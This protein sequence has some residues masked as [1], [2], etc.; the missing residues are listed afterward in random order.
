MVELFWWERLDV[1]LLEVR[2]C[3]WALS[4]QKPMPGPAERYIKLYKKQKQ[5]KK[6]SK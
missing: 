2:H 4:F 1:A 5:K 3:Q 6:K